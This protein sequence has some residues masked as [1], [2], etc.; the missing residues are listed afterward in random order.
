MELIMPLF[1]VLIAGFAVLCAVGS[2]SIS[3]METD[4]NALAF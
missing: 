2:Q 4:K 3:A 1:K